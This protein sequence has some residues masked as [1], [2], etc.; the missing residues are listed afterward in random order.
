MFSSS[1]CRSLICCFRQHTGKLCLGLGS[2]AAAVN[3]LLNPCPDCRCTTKHRMQGQRTLLG[4]S[5]YLGVLIIRTIVFWG[6]YWGPPIL[7]NCLLLIFKDLE[8]H[9]CFPAL[10]SHPPTPHPAPRNA[11][12]AGVPCLLFALML[13]EGGKIPKLPQALKSRYLL[14]AGG[15][16]PLP[17]WCGWAW[18]LRII[19]ERIM[20][21]K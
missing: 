14:C 16:H 6:L 18:S 11:S 3:Y 7:G 12:H 5:Q 21:D 1:L 20:T 10:V 19:N 9:I 8:Q 4:V 13:A 17:R 15:R 2:E